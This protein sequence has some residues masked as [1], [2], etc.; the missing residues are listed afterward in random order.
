MK[1][2]RSVKTQE[3]VELILT[4]LLLRS[5]TV[6]SYVNNEIN[7]NSPFFFFF[8]SFSEPSWFLQNVLWFKK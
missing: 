8:F 5:E 7:I 3:N 2:M 4:G 1:A 6:K